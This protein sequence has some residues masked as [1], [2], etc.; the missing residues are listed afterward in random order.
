MEHDAGEDFRTRERLLEY[1]AAGMTIYF[2]QNA[3]YVDA[4]MDWETSE[5]KRLMDICADIGLK[6]IVT[7]YRFYGWSD[8]RFTDSHITS[9]RVESE[10]A[11]DEKMRGWMSMYMN[12]PAFY[13]V[14]LDDEPNYNQHVP[15]GEI[16]RSIK[17]VCPTAFVQCNLLP[18]V[19]NLSDDRYPT[20]TAEE[21][22]GLSTHEIRHARYKKYLL[23]FVDSCGM[24]YVMFDQYPMG[25]SNIY[26]TYISALQV[27]A[28]VCKE[29]GI[30]LYN[31]TQ[32]FQ[33]N[34]LRKMDEADANWLNNM[35]LGFGVK[36]I[37]YYTYWTRPSQNG[38][39]IVEGASFIDSYGNKTQ[40]YYVMQEI[41]SQN[42]AFAPTIL[43]F[44]Y[45]ASQVL[46]GNHVCST[47]DNHLYDYVNADSFAMLQNVSVGHDI[48][49]VTELKNAKTGQYMYMVQNA[50]DPDCRCIDLG[51]M[52]RYGQPQTVTLTF[53]TSVTEVTVYEKGVARTVALENGVLTLTN[54][55]GYAQ[56]VVVG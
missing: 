11:L 3:A 45:N 9:G 42:Q 27:A 30:D 54:N 53:D 22:A 13:G 48:A 17:R 14:A 12:H 23:A 41:M 47:D 56:Y 44:D 37:A 39:G 32:T 19:Q 49:L 7:D 50:S 5:I 34:G 26:K 21:S 8:H 25:T 35:L 15:Y 38:E 55:P 40:L 16:Y 36:Q 51:C 10:A 31:V 24:D 1:K 20:L 28:E 52:K 43:S 2:P 18:M 46:T 6:V 29:R 33:M 4:G